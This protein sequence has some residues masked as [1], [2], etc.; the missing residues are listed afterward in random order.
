MNNDSSKKRKGREQLQKGFINNKSGKVIIT[1]LGLA[2]RGGVSDTRLSPTYKVIEEFQKLMKVKE[3]RVHD[4]LVI[5]DPTLSA[6]KQNIILTSN[7][8]EAIQGTDLVML[9]A[10]HP[11]YRTLTSTDLGGIPVYDGRGMLDRSKFNH[12]EF[13]SIGVGNQTSL[14]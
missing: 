4:P 10:D 7:L 12:S 6:G 1:L 14:L 11:E 5:K 2:F 8:N 9:I 3:I 13:A